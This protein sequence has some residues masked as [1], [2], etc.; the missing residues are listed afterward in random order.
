MLFDPTGDPHQVNI[1]IGNFVFNRTDEI[2]TDFHSLLKIRHKVLKL[3]AVFLPVWVV[4]GPPVF[5][6]VSLSSVDRALELHSAELL[7][8]VVVVSMEHDYHHV[9]L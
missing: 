6:F 9:W 7:M 4:P 3:S 2:P 5:V 1:H 8:V